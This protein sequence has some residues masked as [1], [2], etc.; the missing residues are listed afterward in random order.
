MPIIE[1]RP[2]AQVLNAIKS[3]LDKL[4]VG[5]AFRTKALEGVRTRDLSLTA[6]HQ[7][8]TLGLTD[9]TNGHGLGNARP[10]GWE[11]LVEHDRSVVASAEVAMEGV[12]G[13]ALSPQLTKG[14]YVQSEK[15]AL[16][17]AERLDQVRRGSFEARLLRIPALYVLAL[18]LRDTE[19]D[20]DIILPLAPAPAELDTSRTYTPEEFTRTLQESA[21]RQLEFDT[22]PDSLQSALGGES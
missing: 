3:R 2:P 18:W 13:S 4:A 8:Y 5:G 20:A 6:P 10:T 1:S 21:R 7:V 17:A 14:P 16:A 19:G 11:Y 12:K 15:Q 22:S 9:L